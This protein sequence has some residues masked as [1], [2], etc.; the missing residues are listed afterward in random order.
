MGVNDL[1]IAMERSMDEIESIAKRLSI[2]DPSHDWHHIKRVYKLCMRIGEEEGAN[3][4]VLKVASL[5]HD[6]GLRDEL[7]KGIDHAERGAAM[8]RDILEEL[9]FPGQMV[10]EITYAIG[11]HRYGRKIKPKTQEAAVL[12]DAD[13]LDALGAIGIARAFADSRT[14]VIYDPTEEPGDYDPYRDRS[15]ITHFYEKLLRLEDTMNT[16][17]ARKIASGRHEF[18][19]RFLDRFF[20]ELGGRA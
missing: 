15:A 16:Q 20:M 1:E 11:V 8:A 2:D 19:E 3:L 13:R 7:E 9:G 12:Q 17:T 6:I 4:D 14:H 10:D 18:M 5:L